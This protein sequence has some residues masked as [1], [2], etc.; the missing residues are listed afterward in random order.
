V[1]TDTQTNAITE[2]EQWGPHA[3]QSVTWHMMSKVAVDPGA[4]EDAHHQVLIGNAQLAEVEE[5]TVIGLIDPGSADN[6]RLSA[7][8]NHAYRVSALTQDPCFL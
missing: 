8:L 7:N 4:S 3:V 6:S 2:A 1:W 5:N